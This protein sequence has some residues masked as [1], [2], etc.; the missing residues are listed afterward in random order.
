ME[1]VIDVLPAAVPAPVIVTLCGDCQS[2]GAKVRSPL[3][4]ASPV[5]PEAG[6]M[7]MLPEGSLASLIR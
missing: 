1:C 2:P 3:T 7:V 5:S 6:R 4:V